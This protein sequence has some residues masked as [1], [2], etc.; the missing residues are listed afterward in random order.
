MLSRSEF[1]EIECSLRDLS[2]LEFPQ[3]GMKHEDLVRSSS[4]LPILNDQSMCQYMPQCPPSM[5]ELRPACAHFIDR[6][7]DIHRALTIIKSK[8]MKKTFE[9][10]RERY[11]H[12]H[13]NILEMDGK[14][15]DARCGSSL[16][17]YSYHPTPGDAR[18]ATKDLVR[19][20]AEYV[21]EMQGIVGEITEVLKTLLIG[22]TCPLS[23]DHAPQHP[24]SSLA[25]H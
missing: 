4:G 22:A 3:C 19:T 24:A 7:G 14:M 17:T 23:Y 8:G 6:R 25:P 12:L 11:R 10:I 1:R 20:H 18:I 2:E 13:Q 5:T 21:R 16:Y 15:R 9:D